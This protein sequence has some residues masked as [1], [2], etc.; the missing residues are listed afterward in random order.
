MLRRLFRLAVWC[1][2]LYYSVLR[3]LGKI[4][5]NEEQIEKIIEVSESNITDTLDALGI[6]TEG[7]E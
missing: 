5:G 2:R 4:T 1:L 7:D 6:E 3:F